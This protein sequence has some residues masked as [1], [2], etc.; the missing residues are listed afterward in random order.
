MQRS[1]HDLDKPRSRKRSGRVHEI[2][3]QTAKRMFCEEL[4]K[5]KTIGEALRRIGRTRSGYEYW[6]RE[7]HVFREEVDTILARRAAAGS[8]IDRPSVPDFPEFCETYLRKKLYPH[9]LRW[10]DLLEGR[11]PRDL[12]PSM[13]YER[14]EY[15]D[16]S[17]L[18]FNV[19]PEFGKSATITQMYT[20]WRIVKNPSVRIIVISESQNMAKKFI[21]SVKQ[22][23][24]HPSY[25]K[26][27]DH[28]APPEGWEATADSWTKTEIY[29][30]QQESE[31][32]KDPTLQAL[33]IGGQIYGARA[34]LIIL[35]DIASKKSAHRYEWQLEYIRQDC[36]TR[37]VEEEPE[38]GDEFI[39]AGKM[40]LVGTRVGPRDIY[41]EMRKELEQDIVYFAQPAVLDYGGDDSED[42]W[43]G[44]QSL[45]PKKWPPTRLAKRRRVVGPRIWTLVYQ[46]QD[47]KE[48]AVFP[49]ELVMAAC[50]GLRTNGPMYPEAPGHR[51]E[52][53]AGL[54]VIGSMD[55]AAAG[56]TAMVVYAVDK[57]TGKRYVLDIWNQAGMTPRQKRERMKTWTEKYGVREW[58]VEDNAVQ[59]DYS[60]DEDV[61]EWMFNR[62]VKLLPHHTDKNKWD[63][64]FG[65]AS[66][67]T[68][69]ECERDEEGNPVKLSGLIELP[70]PNKHRQTNDLVEQLISWHPETKGRTDTVMALWFAEIR[71]RELVRRMDTRP[72]HLKNQFLT[73]GGAKRRT[74]ISI[75]DL[76]AQ[77]HAEE[78]QRVG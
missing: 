66:M 55:P 11:D 61:K 53:M 29:L 77:K 41:S 38:E 33:G 58:R 2:D 45:W 35:D 74:V 65:V 3:S 70:N 24:T 31:G 18:I 26:L 49:P 48:D 32:E 64:E 56:Y 25:R 20:T 50:N 42:G 39:L 22:Y 6:R 59:R 54:Y 44:W 78:M 16:G 7:D 63:P 8:A 12:H 23:L 28:F 46:Q 27:Q 1:T 73:R 72:T 30:Q 36:L 4:R 43:D 17:M 19:P 21:H 57:M 34:D 69:F 15:A 5:N 14:G 52:G 62:G 47:V 67:E 60:Q 71:A 68:L 13:T 9:Q 37:L 10:F 75:E 40:L 51:P 76:L